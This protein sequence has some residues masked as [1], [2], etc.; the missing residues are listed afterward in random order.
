M[1]KVFI[2]RY[3]YSLVLFCEGNEKKNTALLMVVT[4]SATYP[5]SACELFTYF[6]RGGKKKNYIVAPPLPAQKVT[7]ASPNLALL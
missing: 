3:K 4:K 5:R 6:S 1:K 7:P 2:P